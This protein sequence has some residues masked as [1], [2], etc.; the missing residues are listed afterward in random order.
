[1]LRRPKDANL[2]R[3]FGRDEAIIDCDWKFVS[4]LTTLKEPHERM[5]RLADL[6]TYLAEHGNE[7]VWVLLDIKLDVDPTVAM[8]LIAKAIREVAPSPKRPWDQR[9][10]LGFWSAKYLPLCKR[11]LPT[12]PVTYIGFSSLYARQFFGHP[13]V[14][15]NML[16]KILLLWPFGPKFIRDAHARSRSVLVWTVNDDKMMRW[17]IKN[18]L[19]GVITDDPAR[20][21][22]VCEE[23]TA[24]KRETG[25]GLKDMLEAL[26]VNILALLLGYVFIHLRSRQRR[27]YHWDVMEGKTVAGP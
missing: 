20:F 3:C 17:A 1:V 8:S 6:L 10:I 19:D 14:C 22:E 2:K 13:H 11:F 25:L 27:K 26:Y 12:F 15:F 21:K 7:D 24:G 9:I 4:T 23:W 16:A 18:G 5:P